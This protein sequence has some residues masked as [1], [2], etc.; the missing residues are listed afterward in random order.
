MKD[1]DDYLRIKIDDHKS[2]YILKRNIPEL[3]KPDYSPVWPI[4]R[5]LARRGYWNE[6][7]LSSILRDKLYERIG[8]KFGEF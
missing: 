3:M 7:E 5:I 6:I 2:K 4:F 1:T 8:F